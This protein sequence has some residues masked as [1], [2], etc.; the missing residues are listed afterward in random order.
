MRGL[1]ASAIRLQKLIHWMKSMAAHVPAFTSSPTPEAIPE[2]LLFLLTNFHYSTLSI[3]LRA[4]IALNLSYAS[5]KK[6]VYS[7]SR[8]FP[9]SLFS[10]PFCG[11]F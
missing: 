7:E 2:T 8:R 5:Y 1:N 3:E 9:C 11:K 6:A 10:F 4:F